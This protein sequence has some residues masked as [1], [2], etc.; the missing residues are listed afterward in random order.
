MLHVDLETAK[1]SLLQ[2]VKDGANVSVGKDVIYRRARGVVGQKF[3]EGLRQGLY[4]AVLENA[5]GTFYVGP[6]KAICDGIES[7][8][9][10][11]DGGFWVSRADP[12]DIRIFMIK[13]VSSEED[14]YLATHSGVLIQKLNHIGEGDYFIYRKDT[15]FSSAMYPILHRE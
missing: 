11:F 7:C 14:K 1:P 13:E 8:D 15:D 6:D 9:F 10:T 3:Q 4:R 5:Q 2:P 12:H